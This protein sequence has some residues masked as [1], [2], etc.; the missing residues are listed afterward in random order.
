MTDGRFVGEPVPHAHAGLDAT[1]ASLRECFYYPVPIAV[2]P[3]FYF[4]KEL[5]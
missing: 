2:L 1:F 3:W 5:G 4:N